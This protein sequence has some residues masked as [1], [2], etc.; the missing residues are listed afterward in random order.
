MNK[1]EFPQA[2]ELE[3]KLEKWGQEK[4]GQPPLIHEQE[5]GKWG[6]PPFLIQ[7]HE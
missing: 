2:S 6:Q 1:L 7:I 4:W 5:M 3:P